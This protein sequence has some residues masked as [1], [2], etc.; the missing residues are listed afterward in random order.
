MPPRKSKR[1]AWRVI[2][3]E[4]VIVVPSTAT[5]LTLNE[6]GTRVFTLVDGRRSLE[7]IARDLV[8]GFEID[9]ETA[10]RDTR[11]FLK[12]LEAKEVVDPT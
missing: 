11:A 3:G 1:I 12:E 4:A 9:E 6:V 5:V 8:E 10:A 7:E 2:G